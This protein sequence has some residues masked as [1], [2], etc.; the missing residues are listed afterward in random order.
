MHKLPL[1]EA[2]GIEQAMILENIMCMLWFREI[3]WNLTFWIMTWL[4][5][6]RD[7]PRDLVSLKR[8]QVLC[9]YMGRPDLSLKLVEQVFIVEK[10]IVM[11]RFS[12]N[13]SVIYY[14]SILSIS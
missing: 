7:F 9:F 13:L 10:K 6:L 3:L 5:L 1:I 11:I 4:Q 14:L 2:A 12:N 8:G